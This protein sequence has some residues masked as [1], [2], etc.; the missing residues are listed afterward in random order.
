MILRSAAP[1]CQSKSHVRVMCSQPSGEMWGSSRPG[2]RIWSVIRRLVRG[3]V[4]VES[5]PE[6]DR[7]DD[8]VESHGALLLRGVRSVVDAALNIRAHKGWPARRKKARPHAGPAAASC[9][10]GLGPAGTRRQRNV[11]H[12]GCKLP[13]NRK[14]N[15]VQGDPGNQT[16]ADVA[17]PFLL[18]VVLR[19]NYPMGPIVRTTPSTGGDEAGGSASLSGETVDDATSSR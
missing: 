10:Y 13:R 17:G 1:E 7:G 16:L 2:S 11:R 3:L 5:V 15:R 4:H 19:T 18:S 6:N 12:Q 8:E 14:I 9:R